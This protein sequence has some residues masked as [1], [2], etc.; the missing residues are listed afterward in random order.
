MGDLESHCEIAT[1]SNLAARAQH[2]RFIPDTRSEKHKPTV[3]CTVVNCV[4]ETLRLTAFPAPAP[5]PQSLPVVAVSRAHT[6]PR[7]A[8]NRLQN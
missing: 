3:L 4:K 1:L 8:H 7:E 6:R 2:R 5:Y